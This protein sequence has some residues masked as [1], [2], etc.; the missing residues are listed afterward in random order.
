M[1]ATIA[2]TQGASSYSYTYTYSVEHERVRFEW[3]GEVLRAQVI[4]DP[5][6]TFYGGGLAA[7]R[8]VRDGRTLSFWNTDAW[9]YGEETQALYQSH[10]FVLALLPTANLVPL[11]TFMA[12]SPPMPARRSDSKFRARAL[13]AGNCAHAMHRSHRVTAGR[14]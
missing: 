8:L 5:R 10:P 11:S 3:D 2:H 6:A 14:A 4:V 13:P 1:P 12:V 7:G 9:R